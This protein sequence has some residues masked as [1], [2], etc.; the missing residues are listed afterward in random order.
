MELEVCAFC[1][2]KFSEKDGSGFI[3]NDGCDE[4][5]VCSKECKEDFYRDAFGPTEEDELNQEE[6]L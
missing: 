1:D 5:W 6:T 4:Y 3:V 2:A